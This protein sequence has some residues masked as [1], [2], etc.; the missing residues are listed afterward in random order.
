LIFLSTAAS[1]AS[2][3]LRSHRSCRFSQKEGEHAE[4]RRYLRD[5]LEIFERLGTLIEPDKARKE[6][7]ELP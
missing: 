3:G 5:A 4:A 2:A 7:G 6:L 1:V